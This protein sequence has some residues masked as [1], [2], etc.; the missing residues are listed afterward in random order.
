MP[1][2]GAHGANTALRDA[3]TL[4]AGLI[5]SGS[6]S[7]IAETIGSYESAMRDYSYPAV[8]GALRMMKFA[9]AAFPFKRAIF[10]SVAKIGSVFSRRP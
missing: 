10:R 4:A 6:E 3:Q 8:L 9:T 1:P 5:A 7:H 2:Y